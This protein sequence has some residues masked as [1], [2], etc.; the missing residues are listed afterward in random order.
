MAE[1]QTNGA[2]LK[3]AGSE[4][5]GTKDAGRRRLQPM[6]SA[7]SLRPDGPYIAAMEAD[8]VSDG[9]ATAARA[10]AARIVD[11]LA[12]RDRGERE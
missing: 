7:L 6:Y 1:F 2:P 8:S 3:A 5:H 12:E 4:G 10:A 11:S 9:P